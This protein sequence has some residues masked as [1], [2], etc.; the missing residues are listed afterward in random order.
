LS[1]LERG[2][3]CFPA[4]SV[5]IKK[6]CYIEDWPTLQVT[7][8]L[9][10]SWRTR[11]RE[12]NTAIRCD[13]L[14]VLDIDILTRTDLNE[15]IKRLASEI[16][17]PT[18]F[19]RV[20]L[21]PKCALFY[22]AA[23]IKWLDAASYRIDRDNGLEVLTGAKLIT[24]HGRH[25]V[26]GKPYQWTEGKTLWECSLDEIPELSLETLQEFR[27][28]VVKILPPQRPQVGRADDPNRVLDAD[29]YVIDGRET[30]L[31]DCIYVAARELHLNNQPITAEDVSRRGWELFKDQA[32]VDDGRWT[33]RDAD[34]K[35]K[36]IVK[37]IR[38]GRLT[39]PEITIDPTYP[40]SNVINT[41]GARSH[42]KDLDRDFLNHPDTK[43]IGQTEHV[44][45]GIGKTSIMAQ[46]ITT[47]ELKIFFAVPTHRL[48]DDI[49]QTF[50]NVNVTARV[51]RGRDAKEPG[52]KNLMCLNPEQTQLAKDI[53]VN[54]YSSCCKSGES[55]CDRYGECAYIR[56]FEGDPVQVTIGAHELL[57]HEQKLFPEFD[58]V[59]I[60]ESF[61]EAGVDIRNNP[62]KLSDLEFPPRG[63]TADF[64]DILTDMR[65]SR[66][67]LVGALRRHPNGA[68][69]GKFLDTLTPEICERGIEL[70]RDWMGGRIKIWPGMPISA[71][72]SQQFRVGAVQDAQQ[73]ILLWYAIKEL[74]EGERA[75]DAH[76]ELDNGR[77]KYRGVKRIV[78][79]FQK[80]T[81]VMDATLPGP[82]ILNQF[83][84]EVKSVADFEVA[85]PHMR[86]RQIIDAP[87]TGLRL[88]AKLNH[89]L[90]RWYILGRW[91]EVRRQPTLVI[92]QEKLEMKLDL[93]SG[94]V[95]EHFN[96]ILGIDQHRDVRLIITIGRTQP[97]PEVVETYAAALTGVVPQRVTGRWYNKVIRGIRLPDGTGRAVLCDFH[98]DPT[99][100]AVR[101]QMCEAELLQAIGRGRGVN[102]TA[103]TPLDVD[104]LANVCLP[105]TV[106]GVARWE[107]PS[108][109]VE[110]AATGIRLIS[111]TH[112]CRCWPSVWRDRVAAWEA[113]KNLIA[114]SNAIGPKEAAEWRYIFLGSYYLEEPNAIHPFRYRVR[115][116]N[117]QV[118]FGF[119]EPS[120]MPDLQGWLEARLGP[121]A[122]FEM[123]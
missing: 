51:I 75:V 31:R 109:V 103:E 94:I 84:P 119:N 96:N 69:E 46:A 115:G 56:Q 63:A 33:E 9:I 98:P 1:L 27:D 17:G 97:G 106:D 79:Q 20:G 7:R 49:A 77:V 40:T 19:V 2:F 53:D 81:M 14:I 92:T 108:S 90:L 101:W 42:M 107:A 99:C 3:T 67:A 25:L 52:T 65:A 5:G 74:L 6:A 13:D 57:F 58:K 117:E 80:P 93:P 29:G 95:V 121:L 122:M 73:I 16:L 28:A 44:P 18:P 64:G 12:T 118:T 24:V 55:V 100:E 35:A 61:W 87:V 43:H 78:K 8:E 41:E 71:V 36:T 82:E 22:R 66:A 116:R 60:D 85:A 39:F 62:L 110:M 114:K 21:A 59:I 38:A 91:L 111:P 50:E 34:Q 104:I 120:V 45:T 76:H 4:A 88:D 113:L 105:L 10:D 47:T 102:R 68:L 89:R 30:F 48:G 70:E 72:H 112:M 26:T 32:R 37:R 54:I 23:G 11:D 86:V 123:V 15:Q 83:F